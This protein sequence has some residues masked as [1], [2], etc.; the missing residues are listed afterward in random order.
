M[1]WWR[2]WKGAAISERAPTT[3]TRATVTSSRSSAPSSWWRPRTPTPWEALRSDGWCSASASE[4][5]HARLLLALLPRLMR[6]LL[7]ALL[8]GG[9]ALAGRARRRGGGAATGTIAGS[10]GRGWRRRDVGLE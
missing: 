2:R 5:Q 10:R 7:L 1:P 3:G 9:V 4:R 8:E 6:L